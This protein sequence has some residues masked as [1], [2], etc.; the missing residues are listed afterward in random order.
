M[1]ELGSAHPRVPNWKMLFGWKPELPPL[2]LLCGEEDRFTKLSVKLQAT[3]MAG[4]GFIELLDIL[5]NFQ[6]TRA[7]PVRSPSSTTSHD[8]TTSP[9]SPACFGFNTHY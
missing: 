8:I 5:A 7:K 1:R 9:F 6:R 3:R 4:T 2:P